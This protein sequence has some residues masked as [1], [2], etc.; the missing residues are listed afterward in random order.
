MICITS[1]ATAFYDYKKALNNPNLLK[2]A[3]QYVAPFIWISV[4]I[5]L[6]IDTFQ[7]MV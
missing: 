7:E 1:G 5:F 4:F 6:T 2:I 3:L